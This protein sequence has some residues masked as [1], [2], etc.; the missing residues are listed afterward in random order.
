MINQDNI[1]LSL[2]FQSRWVTRSDPASSPPPRR[3]NQA[4]WGRGSWSRW[5]TRFLPRGT[6][7][8]ASDCPSTTR[9]S[10]G[11]GMNRR[12]SPSLISPIINVRCDFL[13]EPKYIFYN[14]ST[15]FLFTRYLQQF[16]S[17]Y[18]CWTQLCPGNCVRFI[19]I[20]LKYSSLQ[21]SHCSQYII[22]VNN[23]FRLY[24]ITSYLMCVLCLL[25]RTIKG[26][27]PI[28]IYIWEI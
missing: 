26:F 25:Y 22:Y 1:Q 3:A 15:G 10:G 4:P 19:I 2:I 6:T 20:V 24:L 14:N 5:L 28:P 8:P 13:Q 17:I 7:W 9:A 27:N 16:I 11:T 18:Y 21:S 23:N 12:Y